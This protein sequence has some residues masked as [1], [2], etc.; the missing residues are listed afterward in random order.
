MAEEGAVLIPTPIGIYNGTTNA[1]ACQAF[2][3]YL[4]S[5][6]AQALFVS[7]NYVSINPDAPKPE[8]Y[9]DYPGG[10]KILVPPVEFMAENREEL[11]NK[12]E[13]LFGPPPEA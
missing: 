7:Q 2:L 9:A 1:A 3:D 12:Y 8:G 13:D 4:Y 11:R 5:D 10:I 6:R